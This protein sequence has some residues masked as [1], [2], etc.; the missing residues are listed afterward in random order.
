MQAARLGVV[1]QL[2]S[3][4]PLEGDGFEETG[5]DIHS[6]SS[7]AEALEHLAADSA[8]GDA[9][10][11]ELV[12]NFIAN[13]QAEWQRYLDAVGDDTPGGAVTRGRSTST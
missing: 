2:P 4:P 1:D 13:K 3:P 6:A 12:A 7:L 11:A 9:V 10:G 8:L 5:T